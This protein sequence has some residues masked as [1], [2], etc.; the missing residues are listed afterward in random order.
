MSSYRHAP[1][2]FAA[3]SPASTTLFR[4]LVWEGT[5]PLEIRVDPK[6]LPANSNRGL[7]VCFVQA[8]RVSYLPLLVPD[9]KRFLS[10]IVFDDEAARVLNEEDW[11]F[12]SEEGTLLKWHW[13][14][15][16]IYDNHTTMQSTKPA[17][18]APSAPLRLVLHL[19]SPPTDKLLLAPSAEACKQAFMG[20]LKE[21]DFL[22]WGSTKRMTGLRKQEQDGIW[23][24][25]KEHNFDE[26]WRVAGKVTPTPA[27]APRPV[28]P[29]PASGHTRPPS[30]DPQGAPDRDG[31]YGVRS[32]PVRLYL[33]DGPVLQDLA[34]PL[35]ED[36]SPNTLADFLPLHLS[37]LFPPTAAGR[38]RAFALVQGVRAPLEAE[39]AWLGACMAGADGWVN[40]CIGLLR[41]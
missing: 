2:A 37:A 29:P 33:P 40:V 31:A 15:G 41:S 39:L 38:P 11:W 10:D 12:E 7:E 17:P 35:L 34:P 27:P 24:G 16:L 5:V 26:Y 30:A 9:L 14:I 13:P 36:G 23:E 28:S 25:I 21:A 18:T 20:Q 6:E 4:R 1:S 3:A 22:R 19:A 32:V 8:S